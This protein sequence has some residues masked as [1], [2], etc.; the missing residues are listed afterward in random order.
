MAKHFPL[1]D[2]VMARGW[3]QG[4]LGAAWR[5]RM[6]VASTAMLL[7]V[8]PPQGCRSRFGVEGASQPAIN[9]SSFPVLLPGGLKGNF[10]S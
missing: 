6:M 2:G 10:P 8:P 3:V 7:V 9:N 1:R 4:A 5:Q